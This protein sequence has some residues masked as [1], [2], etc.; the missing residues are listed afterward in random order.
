MHLELEVNGQTLVGAD[1]AQLQA[2]LADPEK[3]YPCVVDLRRRT[4]WSESPAPKF[5]ELGVKYVPL[6]VDAETFSE[7]DMDAVRREFARHW[8]K[9][10]VVS[11]RGARSCFLVLAHAARVQGWSYEDALAKCPDLKN[12]EQ[13]CAHLRSYLQRHVRA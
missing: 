5:K 11:V 6:P 10:L 8:G 13:L 12:H 4:E 9:V 3:K 2:A 1:L 7:Q